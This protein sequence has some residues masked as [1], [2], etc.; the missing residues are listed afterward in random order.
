MNIN[1]LSKYYIKNSTDEELINTD[2]GLVKAFSS[3]HDS[4]EYVAFLTD[5]GTKV[6]WM[7]NELIR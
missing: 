3:P 1:I 7:L 4:E 6:V 5:R 2:L